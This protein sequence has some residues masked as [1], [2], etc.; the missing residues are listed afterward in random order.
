MLIIQGNINSRTVLVDASDRPRDALLEMLSNRKLQ[1]KICEGLPIPPGSFREI[2]C[3]DSALELPVTYK[4][5]A[6]VRPQCNELKLQDIFNS[7]AAYQMPKAYG[8]KESQDWNE[9]RYREILSRLFRDPLS[10]SWGLF[11]DPQ[12]DKYHHFPAA[13]DRVIY[14][15]PDKLANRVQWAPCY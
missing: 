6:S 2:C 9:N 8:Q 5:E 13:A 15:A 7:N 4:F 12:D 3:F 14:W 11:F 10:K 1:R